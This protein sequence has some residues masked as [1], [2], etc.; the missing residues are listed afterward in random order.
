[1]ASVGPFD[2]SSKRTVV[3]DLRV[4]A[5]FENCVRPLD[6]HNVR[7]KRV[8]WIC[9]RFQIPQRLTR[10]E[11]IFEN[12]NAGVPESILMW[13]PRDGRKSTVDVLVVH[14]RIRMSIMNVPS[15]LRKRPA[16][17]TRLRQWTPV[18]CRAIALRGYTRESRTEIRFYSVFTVD[19][20]AYNLG[21][22]TGS[23]CRARY[24][25]ASILPPRSVRLWPHAP[26]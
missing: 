19:T 15:S 20:C 1:M 17:M 16:K 21:L 12:A 6:V 2:E 10:R 23:T 11:Y 18:N 9:A 13:N 5:F 26:W 3:A 25:L 24:V 14:V 4:R 22:Q 8:R 7:V